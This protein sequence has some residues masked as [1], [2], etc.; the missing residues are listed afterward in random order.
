MNGKRTL[1]LE[2]SHPPLNTCFKLLDPPSP[3]S[4]KSL[5][6]QVPLTPTRPALAVLSPA[7]TGFCPGQPRGPAG[8]GGEGQVHLHRAGT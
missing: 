7:A 5:Q 6:V 2:I 3:S 8:G 1:C 4:G